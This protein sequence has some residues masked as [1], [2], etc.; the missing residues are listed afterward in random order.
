R[1]PR[2][3]GRR[4]GEGGGKRGQRQVVRSSADLPTVAAAGGMDGGG[5]NNIPVVLDVDALA[6][7]PEQRG[8]RVAKIQMPAATAGL[9][10]PGVGHRADVVE[11]AS[12]AW[13]D[14][15]HRERGPRARRP[16]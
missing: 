2:A 10:C 8:A 7:F 15:H 4:G 11:I 3:S 6:D 14:V 5:R 9:D 16:D 12:V 13:V 1:T